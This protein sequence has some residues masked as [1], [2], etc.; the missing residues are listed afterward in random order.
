MTNWTCLVCWIDY[1]MDVEECASCGSKRDQILA[2]QA[3]T[4]KPTHFEVDG[5]QIPYRAE[6]SKGTEIGNAWKEIA[7]N[8]D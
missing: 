7:K 6:K 5:E 3:D 4:K 2:E 8:R 1:G